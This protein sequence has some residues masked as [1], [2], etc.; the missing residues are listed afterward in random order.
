MSSN[1]IMQCNRAFVSNL[2]AAPT[3]GATC[4]LFATHPRKPGGSGTAVQSTFSSGKGSLSPVIINPDAMEELDLTFHLHDHASAANGL[5]AYVTTDG[6]VTWNETD[7]K[8]YVSGVKDQ[9]SIGAAATIQVP[10]LS[11]GQEWAETFVIGRYRGFALEYT[12]GATPPTA[13]TGWSLSAAVKYA[14]Q[15]D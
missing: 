6:G 13:V 12:A 4:V 9:P 8:G 10:T 3:T 14:P 15:E 2:P 7:M 11:A 1:V 5:R